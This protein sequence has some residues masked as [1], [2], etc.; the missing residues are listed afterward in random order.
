MAY[1][2][3]AGVE[4]MLGLR[5]FLAVLVEGVGLLVEL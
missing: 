1:C 3:A 4:D 2:G 5:P